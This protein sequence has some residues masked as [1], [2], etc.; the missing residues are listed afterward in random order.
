MNDPIGAMRARVTLQEPVRVADEIGGAVIGWTPRGEVWAE[1]E[2]RTGFERVMNDAAF[3]SA[4]LRVSIR[5]REEV[6]YPWRIVWDSR[7]LRVIG[8]ADAGG[9]RIVLFCREETL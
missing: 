8:R 5:S 6:R 3:S 7:I 2:A 4:D 1:I 9:T